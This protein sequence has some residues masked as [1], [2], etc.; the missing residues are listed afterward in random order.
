MLK[1]HK[2]LGVEELRRICDPAIFDF[3]S[4]S[5]LPRPTEIIEQKRAVIGS[6]NQLG[7]IQA[8]GRG[9]EKIEGFFDVCKLKNL[10]GRQG[11]IIP[12]S[13]VKNRMLRG[14]VVETVRQGN[15][16]IYPVSTI[17]E[18]VELLTG[19]EAGERNE[20]GNYSEN[21]MNYAV[22]ARLKELSEKE[23]AF[24]NNG[25][26]KMNVSDLKLVERCCS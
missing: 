13:N 8:I 16:H 25:K 20:K 24:V 22:Q 5:D 9:N 4:T 19:I 15:F 21:T 14:D 12:Q 1:T 3:N 26:H 7:R 23:Q 18:G 2:E 6:V 11:V 17:D 10:T